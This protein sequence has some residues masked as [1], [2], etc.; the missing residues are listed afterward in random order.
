[1]TQQYRHD[2]KVKSMKRE[3]ASNY[4][5]ASPQENN[6]NTMI[7]TRMKF[8]VSGMCKQYSRNGL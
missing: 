7:N 5:S 8:K 1:M 4:V 2:D 6:N 3:H